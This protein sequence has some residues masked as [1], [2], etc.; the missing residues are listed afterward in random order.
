MSHSIFVRDYFLKY[1]KKSLHFILME[2]VIIK[3]FNVIENSEFPVIKVDRIPVG[4]D[5]VEIENEMYYA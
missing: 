1:N 5:P 3:P 2:K 4:G